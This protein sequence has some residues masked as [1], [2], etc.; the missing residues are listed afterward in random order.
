MVTLIFLSTA[1]AS[2]PENEPV[3]LAGVATSIRPV[4]AELAAQFEADHEISVTLVAGASGTLAEQ[5]RQGAPLDLIISADSRYT[6]TLTDEGLLDPDSLAVLATGELVAITNSDDSADDAPT[7]L[8][9][10]V[11]Q[12][13]AL[14]NPDLAPYGYAARRYLQ[15]QRLW[16]ETVER[17]VYGENVAQAF[18]FVASGNAE[19]GFVPRSLL[20][21]SDARGIRAL[22]PLPPAASA[23]LQV[24]VGVSVHSDSTDAAG[25]FIQSLGDERALETWQRFGYA[26]HVGKVSGA[27]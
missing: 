7:L 22:A 9:D 12:H 26:F 5:L 11:V 21:A 24:T 19:L 23:G 13:V 27:E 6:S 18:H 1:C 17:V 2:T 15:D 14:A 16:E 10:S 20:V 25:S 8:R 4:V 3:L